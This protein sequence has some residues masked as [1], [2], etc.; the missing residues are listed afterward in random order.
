MT[1]LTNSLNCTHSKIKIN[2][3]YSFISYM[4]SKCFQL[5]PSRKYDFKSGFITKDS[6]YDYS[7]MSLDT[8]NLDQNCFTKLQ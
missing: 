1:V 7:R 3:M 5:I 2:K 8:L 4:I 6:P